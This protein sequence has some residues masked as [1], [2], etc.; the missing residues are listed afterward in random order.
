MPAQIKG[1][2]E[3]R[4]SELGAVCCLRWETHNADPDVSRAEIAGSPNFL[5]LNVFQVS[6]LG[7]VGIIG[8]RAGCSNAQLKVS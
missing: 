5:D 7:I 4:H 3:H 2:K 1:A 8:N 6:L